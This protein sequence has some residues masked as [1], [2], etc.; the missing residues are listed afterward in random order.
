MDYPE[1]QLPRP[2]SA[3]CVVPGRSGSADAM[4][5]QGEQAGTV[6]A[7]LAGLRSAREALQ[8]ADAKFHEIQE[9]FLAEAQQQLLDLSIEIAKKVLMQEIQAD[10]HK[11]DP[12]VT[13][14][15]S[16]VQ[17]RVDVVV[18]L[19]PS[20]LA[21]CELAGRADEAADKS[22]I[23]FVADPKVQR[24]GCLLQTSRGTV[25]S[26]IDGQLEEIS[27]ALKNPE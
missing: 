26:S 27:Q 8:Q 16:R 9:Q 14:A 2:P 12:I 11:I 15:L 20:D 19:H 3:V 10:R 7:E 4:G 24:G 13:E 18:H 17:D 22:N 25:E 23:S 6:D 21:R 5:P 1:I